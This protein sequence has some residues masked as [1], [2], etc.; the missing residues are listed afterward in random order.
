MQADPVYKKNINQDEAVVNFPL[1]SFPAVVTIPVH[2]II[3]HP[4]GQAVGTGVNFSMAHIQSQIDVLNE[5]FR[6]LNADA[7]NTPSVFPAADSEI[8]FCLAAFDPSGNPTNGVTRY[9]T[10]QNLSDDE[11]AIKSTTGWDRNT[12]LNCWVGNGLGG[13][14]GWAYLPS[15]NNLPNATLDGIVVASCTFGGPGFGSCGPYDLG[16]TATHEVGHYLGLRH[17]W[18]NGGCNSD[19]NIADTP[20]QNSSN[21]GCPNH[22]SPSCSN[23]GDMFMNYMDYVNDDC[24]NA[25]T[26]GQNARM[27]VILNNSRSSLL[28]A[29]AIACNGQ[30]GAGLTL[31]LA[32]QT[33]ISC[34]GGNDGSLTVTAAGGSGSYTY[35]ING[36][37]SQSSNTFTD[38][39]TATYTV[40]VDDGAGIASI[41]VTITE[42]PVLFPMINSQTNVDCF[43]N[44]NGV[45]IASASGGTNNT[46]NGYLFDMNGS[47]FTPNNIFTNLSGGTYTLSVQ[48]EN[49]CISTIPVTIIEPDPIL[50]F[51]S[52]EFPIDCAGSN[53]GQVI[54]ETT[55]GAGNYFY[56]LN[57]GSFNPNSIFPNLSA[58]IYV[59][60][61]VD[62]NG[63]SHQFSF[64]LTEPSPVQMSLVQQMDLDCFGDGDGLIEVSAQGG[65]TGYQYSINQGNYQTSPI[66]NSLS[67]GNYFVQ[68]QDGNGCIEFLFV[69]IFEP[70]EVVATITNQTNVGCAGGNTGAVTIDIS[71]GTGT[72]SVLLNGNTAT[73]NSVTFENLPAGTFPFL[74]TDGNNCETFGSVDIFGNPAITLNVLNTQNVG[75]SGQSNGLIEVQA[76]GGSGNFTYTLNGTSQGNNNIFTNLSSGTY[77]IESIDDSGC[78]EL[79]SVDIVEPPVVIANIS[80][81]TNVNCFGGNNGSVSISASGG[82]GNFQYTLGNE[83]NGS[84]T[85]NNLSAGLY[86]VSISD[87]NN[88]IHT[89]EVEITQPE[90]LFALVT[91]SIVVDCF[92][93]NS[94]SLEVSA[95]GGGSNYQFT[96]GSTTNSTGVFNNLSAGNYSISITDINNCQTTI[97]STVTQ[98][99]ELVANISNQQNINCFGENTG[100][101]TLNANGG[102]GNITFT[103]NGN[104]NS[105]GEFS[106]LSGGTYTIIVEDQNSC[107]TNVGI[108]IDEPTELN[109]IIENVTNASCAGQEGNVQ[110]IANGGTGNYQFTLG[111]NT[112]ST[113]FFENLS[114]GNYSIQVVDNNMCTEMVS[115]EITE[116]TTLNPSV[117]QIQN[118]NCFGGNEGTVLVAATGGLGNLTYTLGNET[119]TTGFFQNLTAGNYNII[120]EDENNCTST[121]PF[122]ITQPTELVANITHQQNINCFGESTGS[123]NLE[124]NGGN[125]NNTFTINGNSNSTGEFSNLPSGNYSIIIADQNNCEVIIETV[126][127]EPTELNL[128]LENV[129]EASCTGQEGSLEV[130]ANGGTGNYQFTLG[131]NTNSTGFFVGLSGGIYPVE[132]AD[133]NGCIASLSVEIL[134]PSSLNASVSNIQNISCFGENTGSIQV[135]GNGGSG[136]L[137]FNLGNESN[138]TGT[139]ENLS[140]GNYDIIIEDENNCSS[141]VTLEITQPDELVLTT[142]QVM[143]VN[144]YNGDDGQVNLLSTGGSGT[145]EFTL[146]GQTN[147]NGFFENLPAGNYDFIATDANGCTDQ[148]QITITAPTELVAQITQTQNI[149]CAGSADGSVQLSASG[150]VGGFGYSL[151]GQTNS[152]G[153]FE[154]MEAGNYPVQIVDANNCLVELMVEITAPDPITFTDIQN[155]NTSCNGDAD[156]SILVQGNGGTGNLTYSLGNETNTTG[157]FENLP[158]GIYEV[159]ATDENNCTMTTTSIEIIEPD[160]IEAIIE[161]VVNNSCYGLETGMVDLTANGG[162]GM[163]QFTLGNETNT[164]GVFENLPSGFYQV[165]LEDENN[166]TTIF[167]VTISQPEP[168]VPMSE[169]INTINCFGDSTGIVQISAG[170]GDGNFVF[171]NDNSTNTSGLFENL[172]EGNYEFHISD[173][174]GCE[175]FIYVTLDEPAEIQLEILNS[176]TTGCNGNATG[177]VQASATAGTGIITYEMN[178]ETNTTGFF[179]NLGS[180]VFEL[181]ATDENGCAT[182]ID[183]PISEENDIQFESSNLVNVSCFG[184]DNGA[185]F[186]NATSSSGDLTFELN[187]ITNTTGDFEDLFAGNYNVSIIDVNGC[188]MIIPFEV[189]EPSELNLAINN[190]GDVNCFGT[191]T[192]VANL[193]ATGG[194][195]IFTYAMNGQENDTGVFENLPAGTFNAQVLDSYGCVTLLEVVIAEPSELVT[196]ATAIENDFGNSEGSATIIG[197]GGTE[198][199]MYSLDGVNFQSENV[200]ENLSSGEY[201]GFIQ[202]A[203]GCISQTTFTIDMETGITN[204]N[205]GVSRM[206]ILP[207]PFSEFLYL[208]IELDF[209][210]NLQLEMYTVLG[211]E[212][213]QKTIHLQYGIHQ[214]DLAPNQSLPAGSYILRVRND[215]KSVGYFKLV[216]QK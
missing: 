58:G 72:P 88:C 21:F 73:G 76:I 147:T 216:K 112:N 60:E 198:P 212:V 110:V 1:K 141:T 132:V 165:L 154:G 96:L 4:P 20:I 124:V 201:I 159:V 84:G 48:D 56:S 214:I 62:I 169:I 92:G 19:D 121:L 103:L 115:V 47:G 146:N 29:A 68:V 136:V 82:L 38:L 30:Q 173:G 102:N 111:N 125:G 180:G 94:G 27:H 176:T 162:V 142:D 203:N 23:G 211:Q 32:N 2:V 52:Q 7:G 185:I 11:F 204:P 190:I 171:S 215:E 39:I 109:L 5:D 160:P 61:T 6:R 80:Q 164:T 138:T 172:S 161:N 24:M 199:F 9:G 71:G 25:F 106:N 63:C 134:E 178:G 98:P 49:L 129:T 193:M 33:N 75:C 117:S 194:S 119:N 206:E 66:F 16:R 192:G 181:I 116:P 144:C 187:G 205:L 26:V 200:F 22:P 89:I 12:Y 197:E 57:G 191:S 130:S 128:V 36:G 140:A 175:E 65:T 213:Y 184:N 148:M 133:N 97:Q 195:N 78:T 15:T 188:S 113:G 118:I 143:Q 177:T 28:G 101:V 13:I 123:I 70:T 44:G 135:T 156:G 170:G 155:Q 40:E 168:V 151:G 149:S 163:I 14:L 34:N 122:E 137:T 91:N 10:N 166:C 81:Q 50:S 99:T 104:T 18:G 157:Q 114:G 208:N 54:I 196:S 126:I 37:T 83:T 202:D 59:V 79:I 108:T 90:E 179:E 45:V 31:T 69:D 186:I 131:N 53:S 120:I 77:F 139:F 100:S 67:G 87:V 209:S 46:G 74:V 189:T 174:S 17:V 35:T 182:N 153:L 167:E 183:V 93:N 42:P 43:G 105:T 127:S 64:E 150:G 3:V 51:V 95:T 85:F 158:S 41:N 152:T 145:V 107:Q 8:E 207:N 55:G 210:Q 86:T